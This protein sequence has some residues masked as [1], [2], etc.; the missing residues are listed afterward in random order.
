MVRSDDPD[1]LAAGS[2]APEIAAR[3]Y[4]RVPVHRQPAMAQWPPAVDLPGTERAALSNLALPMGP[5][6]GR[7]TATA[8]ANALPNSG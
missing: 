4:Y 5:T 3:S 8:V 1:A 7:E 2:R 6:L